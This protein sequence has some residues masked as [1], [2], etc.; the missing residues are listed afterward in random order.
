[1]HW[2][3]PAWKA[4][5]S[6][7]RLHRWL[8]KSQQ[9]TWRLGKR[10]HN[11]VRE[12]KACSEWERPEMLRDAA[13][14]SSSRL[15]RESKGGVVQHC[16]AGCS[17]PCPGDFG[18]HCRRL[19]SSRDGK[20][21]RKE[22]IKALRSGKPLLTVTKQTLL[23][24]NTATTW[25]ATSR[26]NGAARSKPSSKTLLPQSTFF[27]VPRT[28]WRW[29]TPHPELFRLGGAPGWQRMLLLPEMPRGLQE[30]T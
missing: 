19:T 12:Q 22:E 11:R 27:R 15:G 10:N 3:H 8:Y 30:S 4:S 20:K 7:I 17:A 23:H 14:H 28:T 26:G 18:E 24:V 21:G 25:D 1:M 13:A 9:T 2:G 6:S 5:R 29:S 16:A